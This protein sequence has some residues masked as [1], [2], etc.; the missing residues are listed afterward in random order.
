MLFLCAVVKSNLYHW[1]VVNQWQNP[2]W[3]ERLV[4]DL[5]SCCA[6]YSII[7]WCLSHWCSH[8]QLFLRILCVSHWCSKSYVSWVLTNFMTWV[9]PLLPRTMTETQDADFC[10]FQLGYAQISMHKCKGQ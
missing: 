2:K 1:H 9:F 6:V 8:Q 5:I 4:L 3:F 7:D 10:I